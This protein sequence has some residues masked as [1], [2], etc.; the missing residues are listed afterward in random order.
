MTPET[1][2]TELKAMSEAE[3]NVAIAERC[4][5]I[6]IREQDCQ[7]PNGEIFQI[8]QGKNPEG[9]IEPLPNCC[10]DLN[11][12]HEAEEY[13]NNSPEKFSLWGE[14]WNALEAITECHLF[15]RDI[16]SD[17]QSMIHA[18]AKQRAEAFLKTVGKWK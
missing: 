10:T 9:E 1:K 2:S 5:W 4:G 8:W 6:A 7:W 11:A 12:M 18:T 16:G 3:I 17:C 14:Y 15:D 13:L